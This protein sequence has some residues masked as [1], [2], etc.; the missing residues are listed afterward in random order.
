[1]AT[2]FRLKQQLPDLT[3][4]IVAT[5]SEVGTA[6]HLGTCPLPH[7]GVRRH[8]AFGQVGKLLLESEI[9]RHD[10]LLRLR[11][12]PNV[13]GAVACGKIQSVRETPERARE[14][15]VAQ[16]GRRQMH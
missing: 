3:E 10:R 2:D 6:N 7:L 5:Y 11:C 13:A 8:D 12:G 9:G 15:P 1:M 14:C 4:R 16:T